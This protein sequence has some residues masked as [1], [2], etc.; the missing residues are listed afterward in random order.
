MPC[1]FPTPRSS[2]L[3]M[4][5]ALGRDPLFIRE[6]RMDSGYGVVNLM[7]AALAA[8][9]EITV[10]TLLLYGAQDEVVPAEPT[11]QFWRSLPAEAAASRR[12]G[13]YPEGWHMLL[14]DLQADT[15]IADVAA[16]TH[17]PQAPLPSGAEDYAAAALGREMAGA[18]PET[19]RSEEHTSELQSLM[20]I[21]Y[22]VFCLKKKNR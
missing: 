7:D 13:Y 11:F 14:R 10:P 1:S 9:P 18:Q 15:V 22:A 21:S 17:D 5:R 2:D 20:R 19:A 6:T 12:F 8:A 16:W 3:E 4:R